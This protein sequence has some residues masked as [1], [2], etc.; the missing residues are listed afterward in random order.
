MEL[1]SD[2]V[3]RVFIECLYLDGESTQ[4]HVL[5]HGVTVNVGFHPERLKKNRTQIVK[6]LHQLPEE[7]MKSRGGGHIFTNAAIDKNG[8]QW[9]SFHKTIDELLCLGLA[10]KKIEYL[11]PREVWQKTFGVPYFLVDDEND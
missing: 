10:I 9:T 8:R 3:H 11:L 7:F 2:N 6:M 5:A 4:G 1:T